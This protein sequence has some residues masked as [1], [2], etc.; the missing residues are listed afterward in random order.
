MN[1]LHIRGTGLVM[2]SLRAAVVVVGVAWRSL[3]IAPGQSTTGSG[4][5]RQS[6]DI[7]WRHQLLVPVG[8]RAEQVAEALD[9]ASLASGER[10]LEL[11]RNRQQ[12]KALFGSGWGD[13]NSLEGYLFPGVYEIAS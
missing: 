12:V 2:L 6:D 5:A 11:A 10:F 1:Q 3:V 13:V 9:E 8:W 4:V 7:P